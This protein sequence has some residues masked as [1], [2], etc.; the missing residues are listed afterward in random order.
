MSIRD[1]HGLTL[2]FALILTFIFS[3]LVAVAYLFVG[4]NLKQMQSSLLSTQAVSIAEGI[5]ER[6]KARLNKKVKIKLTPD[7]EKRLKDAGEGGTEEEDDEEF[8]DQFDE[9]T[10]DFD[11]YYADEVLKISRYITFR[12]EPQSSETSGSKDL[13]SR[14]DDPFAKKDGLTEEGQ[15]EDSKKRPEAN[16]HMIGDIEIPAGT[17]L[18]KDTK[19]VIYKDEKIDLM[20]KEITTDKPA[21]VRPKLPIPKIKAL[22]PNYSE[23][24]KRIAFIVQGENLPKND[25]SFNEKGIKIEEIKGGPQIDCL[26]ELD[27]MPGMKRFYWDSA[28]AEF[29]I[30]PTFDGSR[31]PFIREV[32]GENTPLLEI[33]A[34][35]RNV[36]VM[37]TGYD[38][39]QKK[40]PPVV[41]PDVNGITA[42]VKGFAQNG[43][44]ITVSLDIARN[45]DPSSHTLTVATEGGLSN[46]WLFNV[47]PPEDKEDLSYNNAVYSSSLTL[48]DIMVVENVLPVIKDDEDAQNTP[49]DPGN[50]ADPNDPND[51][52][53]PNDPPEP[54]NLSENDKLGK[55]GNTD[56]ETIWL[57]ETSCMIGRITKTVSEVIHRQI[58]NITSALTTNG[59]ISFEGGS[60]QVNGISSATTMLTEPTYLSNTILTVEGPTEDQIEEYNKSSATTASSPGSQDSSSGSG[61]PQAGNNLP[62]GPLELGF[63]EGNLIAVFKEGNKIDELDY[64]QIKSIGSNTIELSPPGLMSFHFQG[65][66]AIQFIPPII[67]REKLSE[68]ESENHINPKGLAVTKNNGASFK[69]I[70]RANLDQFSDLADLYTN[71]PSIPIDEYDLPVG[72]MGLNFIECTPK[73]DQSNVLTG[74]GILILDTRADNNG[75][76]SGDVEFNG[77]SKTPID[78]KGVL[79]VRGN[80]KINGAVNITGALIVDNESGGEVTISSNATGM[81]IYDYQNIKQ[82]I[83]SSPFVT[84]PGSLMISNKPLDL[85]GI[86]QKATGGGSEIQTGATQGVPETQTTGTEG[87]SGTAET[88]MGSDVLPEEATLETVKQKPKEDEDYYYNEDKS[89]EEELIDLF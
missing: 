53:D 1:S 54:K 78:F 4:I 46:V 31:R 6:V 3:S 68:E 56:L 39:F 41:I 52:A 36:L 62:Q 34:G 70:F 71:D 75:R 2:P 64:A 66:S 38:L 33:P 44:E 28:Q 76:P 24:N 47:L 72:F 25:P 32:F 55:F 30:I 27:V 21:Y 83:L 10:E 29:Y 8:T 89:A 17:I 40:S 7:Q 69:N 15:E 5:N 51:P 16:V 88:T 86:V 50:P 14:P 12:D 60:F 82:T 87:E 19:L 59:M 20:L 48:L 35:K 23:A 58:P 85:S 81:I 37:I 63:K 80:L 67:S 74:K 65:D 61:Q 26:I 79:Y 43:N 57:L 22:I 84:K 77:D 42:K 18:E 45:V 73:Y 9:N 49:P 11:E 13:Q